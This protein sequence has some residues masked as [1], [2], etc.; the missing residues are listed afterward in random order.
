MNDINVKILMDNGF[1]FDQKLQL[2]RNDAI[3]KFITHAQA[4]QMHSTVLQRQI[5][6]L[7]KDHE[8]TFI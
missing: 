6:A 2:W 7:K 5:A 1:V 3:Q 8:G 4:M